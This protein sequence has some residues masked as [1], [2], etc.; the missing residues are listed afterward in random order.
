MWLKEKKQE[1]TKQLKCNGF[2]IFLLG[3]AFEHQETNIQCAAIGTR[4]VTCSEKF[5][6]RTDIE[7]TTTWIS[8]E[9]KG[10]T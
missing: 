8:G 4:G 1:L 6:I 7:G 5:V 3:G 2:H 9:K 10:D